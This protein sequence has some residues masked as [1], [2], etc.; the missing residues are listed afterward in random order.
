MF[1]GVHSLTYMNDFIDNFITYFNQSKPISRM[2]KEKIH[3]VDL[4]FD[5]ASLKLSTTAGILT[6][7]GIVNHRPDLK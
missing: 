5:P 3:F 7:K 1:D 6:Q 2:I 4:I